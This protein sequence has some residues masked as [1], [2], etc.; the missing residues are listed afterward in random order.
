MERG[1]RGRSRFTRPMAMCVG[2]AIGGSCFAGAQL[3]QQRSRSLVDGA[4]RGASRTEHLRSQRRPGRR[5]RIP[6]AGEDQ[7]GGEIQTLEGQKKAASSKTQMLRFAL[8]ALGIY[9]AN[10]IM[11]NIDNSF[12]GRFG[13]TT[14]LAALS[15]GG[16]LADNL[17]FLFNSVLSAATT[18]LVARAWPKGVKNA[19]QELTRT[20]TFALAVGVPLTLFYF[21]CSNWALGLMGVAPDV[22]EMAASYARI[23]GL[24]AWASLAQGVCLSA[25]LATRDAVTPL[26]VV[27]TAAAL[28]CL[29]DFLFCCWP[30]QTGVSGAAAA[31]ALSTMAG[32]ALMLRSLK[33]KQILPSIEAEALRDAGPVLEYAGPM[34]IINT[35]RIMGYTAMAFAAAALGTQE[36][37][38]YQVILGIFVLFA[39]VGAPLSQTA[40]SM[41]PPL[42]EANDTEGSR[43]VSGNVLTIATAVSLVAGCLCFAALRFGAQTF[44]NDVAVL[45]QVHSTAFMVLLTTVALLL[46]S[47]IDGALLAAK[48]FR[49]IVFQQGLVVAIQLFLLWMALKM[50]MG[51]PAV[52]MTLA[53]RVMV[54]IPGALAWVCTGNGPLGRVMFPKAKR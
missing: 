25:I 3:L 2:A 6:V 14:A 7:S 16:V 37:A 11:S 54:F 31:T 1:L 24:V 12:V 30:L 47:S 36:L 20:F 34:M 49:F 10:P 29:G 17:F 51:L 8:P 50:H 40:Q 21:F 26:K 39:F 45:G 32:F 46:S 15:P 41:L 42:I 44:T 13:G 53:V 35:T 28:N 18:G 48:D 4:P 52:W 43:K 19:R 5:S 9:L 23:R 33:R 38:A 22:R 27:C